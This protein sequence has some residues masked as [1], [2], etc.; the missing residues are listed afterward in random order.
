M[1]S[2]EPRSL[3]GQPSAVAIGFH[4]A[5]TIGDSTSGSLAGAS[6]LVDLCC[7]AHCWSSSARYAVDAGE[8][9][10][11]LNVPSRIAVDASPEPYDFAST[12][13]G[14]PPTFGCVARNA[15]ISSSSHA[16]FSLEYANRS[17]IVG[18]SGFPSFV[19]V[20]GLSLALPQLATIARTTTLF[21]LMM[22]S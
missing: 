14:L 4:I 8:Y 6:G 12:T 7:T 5:I 2:A 18:P 17:V 13:I 15:G 22:A 9:T 1:M 16:F 21:T 19:P 20:A 10:C 3:L 11:A